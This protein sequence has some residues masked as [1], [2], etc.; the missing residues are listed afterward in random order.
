MVRRIIRGSA[1]PLNGLLALI[2]I[3]TTLTGCATRR[4]PTSSSASAPSPEAKQDATLLQ[5]GRA[6]WYGGKFHGRRTASGEVYD[7]WELTAAHRTLPLGTR[8]IVERV[9][10]GD[11]VT[12]RVND[13]G[14]FVNNRIIDLSR[15]AAGEL[16][17]IGQGTARVRLY[18]IGPGSPSTEKGHLTVQVGSFANP[19]NARRFRTKLSSEFDDVYITDSH[20]PYHRVRVGSFASREEARPVLEKM[21]RMGLETWLVREDP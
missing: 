14:P 10:T 15:A 21:E 20:D 16:N 19:D 7:K 13:R 4:A 2:L 12:V 17:M 1:P 18:R 8:L 9:D 11:R 5:T 3:L 6:S